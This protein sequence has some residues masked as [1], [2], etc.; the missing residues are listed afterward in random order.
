M[1]FKDA[2]ID[3]VSVAS[4]PV[5]AG[6]VGSSLAGMAGAEHYAGAI[7]GGLFGL[8][9][10]IVKGYYDRRKEQDK[11]KHEYDLAL[12]DNER[13][14]ARLATYEGKTIDAG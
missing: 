7:I 13:L 9:T 2:F 8:V 3:W 5:G 1:F 6:V 10:V 11:H 14:R 4:L 12:L